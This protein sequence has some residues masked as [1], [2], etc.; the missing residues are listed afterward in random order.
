MK[1]K[2]RAKRLIVHSLNSQRRVRN[3]GSNTGY[4]QRT[5]QGLSW[6][7]SQGNFEQAIEVD[8]YSSSQN[9]SMIDAESTNAR[10]ELDQLLTEQ[11]Q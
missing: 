7:I 6:Q 3:F 5:N 9:R 8:A 4:Y 10:T 11:A 2:G 1:S